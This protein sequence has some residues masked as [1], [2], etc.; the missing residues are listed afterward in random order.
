MPTDLLL[1]PKPF[2]PVPPA[3]A[4]E[5]LIVR[6]ASAN[7]LRVEVAGEIVAGGERL[8]AGA[9]VT[10]VCSVAV[11]H[12]HLQFRRWGESVDDHGRCGC[13]SA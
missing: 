1:A 10:Y 6:L 9:P 12:L 7:V 11:V 4:P 3:I 8:S 5:T 2:L 13:H